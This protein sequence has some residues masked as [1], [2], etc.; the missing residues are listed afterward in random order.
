MD[1]SFIKLPE[2]ITETVRVV[3]EHREY[4]INNDVKYYY[5]ELEKF[6]NKNPDMTK[7]INQWS[8]F[9]DMERRDL[10]EMACKENDKVKRAQIDKKEMQYLYNTGDAF[11][12]MDGE[13]YEQIEIPAENLEWE[14]NFLKESDTATIRSFEGEVLGVQLPDK[15]TLQITEAEQAVKGDTATG[16]TKNAVLETG[17]QIKVPLFINEGEMVVISTAEGKYSGRA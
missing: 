2:Y 17:F 8:A 14:K 3:K 16:A 11:V 9:L 6:R 10:L 5:I 7:R 1:Y 12:F 4:E 15:V 13:T